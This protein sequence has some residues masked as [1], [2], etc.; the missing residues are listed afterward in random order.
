[1]ATEKWIAGSLAGLTWANAFTASTMN[2]IVNGNA[3]NS[4]LTL[5]NS[6]ALDIFADFSMSIGS[7]AVVAPNYIGVYLMPLNQDGSTFGDGR[8]ASSA[9]GPPASSYWVGNIIVPTGT[10][11]NTGMVRGVMLPPGQWKWNIYNQL[12]V[13]LAG[14]GGN[15]AKYRTYNRQIA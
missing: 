2:A 14:S 15:V 8:F 11:A 13:T 12:G 9:A 6:T 3:I 7:V 5:D 10:A 1:M 4:D